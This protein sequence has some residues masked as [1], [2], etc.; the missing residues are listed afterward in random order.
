M[1]THMPRRADASDMNLGVAPQAGDSTSKSSRIV[2]KDLR[3]S[4]GHPIIFIC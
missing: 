2:H 3:S 1:A 4:F